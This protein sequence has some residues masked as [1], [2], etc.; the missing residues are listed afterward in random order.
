[1]EWQQHRCQRPTF[2]NLKFHIVLKNFFEYTWHTVLHQFQLYNILIQLLYT[3][4]YAPHKYSCHLSPHSTITVPLPI[5]PMLVP[6]M[7]ITYSFHIVLV[8]SELWT[9]IVIQYNGGIFLSMSSWNR[10]STRLMF[11]CHP[12]LQLDNCHVSLPGATRLKRLLTSLPVSGIYGL[13]WLVI[14][15]MGG[16]PG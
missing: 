14:L 13:G 5:F 4:C 15:R 7:P 16:A 1:M 2:F 10:R 9:E 6:F 11:C 8:R 12:W 3:L